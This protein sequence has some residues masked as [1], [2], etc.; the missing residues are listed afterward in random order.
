MRERKQLDVV[1]LDGAKDGAFRA[2]ISSLNVVDQDNDVTVPGAFKDGQRVRIARWGHNW[3][4]LPVGKGVIHADDQRAW[5][6][7]Q[8]LL[9][10]QHGK[11][12][13]LTV[14]D[15]EDLQEW[16]YGYDVLDSELGQFEGKDVRFLKSLDVIEVSPVM[17][18]AGIGTR[19]E[20]IKG[21]KKAIGAHHTETSDAAWDGPANEARLEP[22]AANLRKAHAWQD[23]DADPET[24]TAYKFIHHMV[25]AG[26]TPGAANVKACISSVGILNGGRGGADIPEADRQG[27]WAH[28]AAHLRD[29]DLEPPELR[30]SALRY[31]DHAAVLLAETVA[32]SSRTRDLKALRGKDGRV[33]SAANR[34][35]LAAQLEAIREAAV[36]LEEL[37]RATERTTASEEEPKGDMAALRLLQLRDQARA[38]GLINI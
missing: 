21:T 7:G 12:T 34:A 17:L 16:S 19:T 6:D 38:L 32:F 10:S 29:A 22:G 14:K 9:E 36:D 11:D 13:Y 8:F 25:V 5:V 26:G 27:V 24:K 23:P 28:V 30:K 15:Q 33:L 2:T 3:S 20:S 18:G 1:T 37:L 31:A 4:D 35:R